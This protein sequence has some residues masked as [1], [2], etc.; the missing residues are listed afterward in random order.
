MEE[1]RFQ[2]DKVQEIISIIERLENEMKW[3]V[4]DNT[5]ETDADGNDIYKAPE[6]GAY[7]YTRYLAYIEVLELLGKHCEKKIWGK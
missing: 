4:M 2:L 7:G 6:A 1:R 5:G 3:S